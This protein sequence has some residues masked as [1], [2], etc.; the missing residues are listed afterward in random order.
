VDAVS[1][2]EQK[3]A[4]REPELQEKKEEISGMLECE[5]NDLTSHAADLDARETTMEVEH[6]RLRKMCADLLNRELTISYQENTLASKEEELV[7]KE[8]QLAERQLHELAATRRKMEELHAAQAI[9][10]QR[11][12]DFL[13]QTETVLAPLSFSPLCSGDPESHIE[14]GGGE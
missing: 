4:E 6:E 10:A 7:N 5:H 13:G 12:W 9:E 11:V 2:Q 8:K 1:Q 14:G 3:V